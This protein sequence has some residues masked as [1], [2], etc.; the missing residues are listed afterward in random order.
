MGLWSWY[1][2]NK[3]VKFNWVSK[4]WELYKE[5]IFPMINAYVYHLS[6]PID[7]WTYRNNT[8]K[9]LMS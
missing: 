8:L 1:R 9:K 7:Y 3:P 4:Y 2:V 6:L 5:Y